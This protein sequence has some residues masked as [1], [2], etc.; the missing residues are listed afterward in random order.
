MSNP[1]VSVCINY[2]YQAAGFTFIQRVKRQKGKN[3]KHSNYENM[4]KDKSTFRIIINDLI[5]LIQL[6]ILFIFVTHD[7]HIS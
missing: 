2:V 4:K 1:L 3:G 7:R 6:T 5:I